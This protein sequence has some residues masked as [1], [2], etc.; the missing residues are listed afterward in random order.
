MYHAP[1]VAGF[2]LDEG[3][4][5]GD[6]PH[7]AALNCKNRWW[8]ERSPPPPAAPSASAIAAAAWRRS[9]RWVRRRWQYAPSRAFTLRRARPPASTVLV[10]FSL[11]I[12]VL[13]VLLPSRAAAAQKEGGECQVAAWMW[14]G[15]AAEQQERATY[16]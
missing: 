7:R 14:C 5:I 1:L 6:T 13:I 9:R 2:E 11:C 12:Y 4:E 8:Y 15:V 16:S 3:A 10:P